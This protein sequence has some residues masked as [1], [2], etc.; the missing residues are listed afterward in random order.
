[1]TARSLNEKLEEEAW[2]KSAMEGSGPYCRSWT[3]RRR[4][5]EE[6]K[7]ALTQRLRQQIEEAQAMPNS[8][9]HLAE[10]DVRAG[11]NAQKLA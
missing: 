5:R 8:G 11:D 1:M 10:G 7:E 2:L 9:L 3:R 6:A 4:A